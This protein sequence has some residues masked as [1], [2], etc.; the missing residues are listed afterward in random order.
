MSQSLETL[1]APFVSLTEKEW[2]VVRAH[3]TPLNVPGKTQ[4]VKLEKIATN[5]YFIVKG[6]IRTYYLHDVE[7][8]HTGFYFEKS[9]AAS[10]SSFL[11][12]TPSE[13]VVETLEQSELLC[14]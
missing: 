14:M 3:F 11:N 2:N 6:A 5:I 4:L 9:F 7:E 13:L 10:F 12:N 1:L 8:M